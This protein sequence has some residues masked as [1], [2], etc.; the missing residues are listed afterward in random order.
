[1]L[2][3]SSFQVLFKVDARRELHSRPE[4]KWAFSGNHFTLQGLESLAALLP[5]FDGGSRSYY[6]LRHVTL[7]NLP[8]N[9]A[10]WDYH[11]LHIYQLHWLSSLTR[12]EDYARLFKRMAIRWTAYAKGEMAKHNWRKA[13]YERISLCFCIHCFRCCPMKVWMNDHNPN[14][15]PVWN[16]SLATSWSCFVKER[17]D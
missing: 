1:M 5:L 16:E 17:F 7:S 15:L 12:H 10:R 6:D 14:C 9:I 11:A 3:Q 2:E 13:S 4:G 8:P